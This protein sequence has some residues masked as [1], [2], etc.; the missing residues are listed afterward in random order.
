[1]KPETIITTTTEPRQNLP[2]WE[3]P[4]IEEELT[5]CDH[6]RYICLRAMDTSNGES[7]ALRDIRIG[8]YT[9]KLWRANQTRNTRAVDLHTLADQERAEATKA[10]QFLKRVRISEEDRAEAMQA[11]DHW[12][13]LADND[14]AEATDTEKYNSELTATLAEDMLLTIWIDLQAIKADPDRQTEKAFGELCKTGREFIKSLS[15]VSIVDSMATVSRPLS[16]AEAVYYMTRYGADPK[17]RPRHKW[18][19]TAKGCTGY[20]TLEPKAR[21]KDLDPAKV[22]PVTIANYARFNDACIWYYENIELPTTHST[23]TTAFPALD[24]KDIA[25]RFWMRQTDNEK[26]AYLGLDPESNPVLYLVLHIPTIR[27]QYSAEDMS[28]HDPRT[29]EAVADAVLT[30]VDLIK[31]AEKANL[32][33]QARIAVEALTHPE[34]VAM[35][36]TAYNEAMEKGRASLEELQT[37]RAREGKK[38]YTP[39]KIRQLTEQYTDHANKVY[40]STLW[41]YALTVAEYKNKADAK[42]TI[43][44]KL[45]RAYHNAPDELTPGK[46]NIPALMRSGYRGQAEQTAPIDALKWTTTAPKANHKPVVR[47]TDS[48]HTPEAI[49]PGKDYR[50]ESVL[51]LDSYRQTAPKATAPTRSAREQAEYEKLCKKD[52]ELVELWKAFQNGEPI[53]AHLEERKPTKAT[54]ETAVLELI[55]QRWTARQPKSAELSAV[56]FLMDARGVDRRQLAKVKQ[57]AVVLTKYGTGKVTAINGELVTVKVGKTAH[58]YNAPL[59]IASGILQFT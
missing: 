39:G 3:L 33:Q 45:T 19:Q 52:S 51:I 2:V 48:G 20:Y 38:K 28:D 31:I 8:C 25:T 30:S 18:G 11:L 58:F 42:H 22:D 37:K 47:F 49:N 41:D 9:D 7:S 1:M 17:A 32:G 35:A 4:T 34:A 53:P 59:A 24:A 21:K 36:R 46:L 16:V 57:K 15:S 10:R 26:T 43:I 27:T 12:T 29:A 6:I 50:S 13:A 14:R 54:K 40:S 23:H 44:K 56:A 5:L 55:N